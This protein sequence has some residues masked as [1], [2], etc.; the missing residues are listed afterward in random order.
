MSGNAIVWLGNILEVAMFDDLVDFL[1][2]SNQDR[3]VEDDFIIFYNESIKSWQFSY[4]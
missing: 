3:F 4:L 2:T 1:L